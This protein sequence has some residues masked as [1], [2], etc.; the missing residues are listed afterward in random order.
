MIAAK[1]VEQIAMGVGFHACGVS[2]VEQLVNLDEVYHQWL[3][4]GYHSTLGYMERNVE[5]R[6]NPSLLVPNAKSVVSVLLSY[7]TG[8]LPVNLYPP[9]VS[10]YASRVDYHLLMKQRLREMLNR[11]RVEF[12]EVNGRAFVDSA[13][14]MER[15]WAVRAGLGWIGKNSN[16]INRVLGSYVFIGELIVD[17]AIEPTSSMVTN[18]CGNCTRCIDACP[19]QAIVAPGVVDA[20]KCISYLNIERKKPISQEE[21]GSLNGWCFGCDICQEVCP[22][23]KK[24]TKVDG[25]E[26]RIDI[27][28]GETALS[29]AKYSEDEFNDKFGDTPL[30]RAGY[31]KL[32]STIDLV[33]N[34]V[35]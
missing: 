19:N 26:Q 1:A 21:V 32:K 35:K 25:T 15:E 31:E 30:P 20:R 23:N 5:L 13:P 6:L 3:S 27:F 9:R 33:V 10:R 22:W 16:L 34:R 17:V 11:L 29:I 2:R 24:A 18:R 12:G 7:N 14:V 4:K 8:D 28:K